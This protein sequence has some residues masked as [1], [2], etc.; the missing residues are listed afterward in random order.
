MQFQSDMLDVP[1]LKANVSEMSALGAAY[2]GGLGIGFWT[3]AEEITASAGEAQYLRYLPS[4]E[5]NRRDELYRGWKKAVSS[6][7]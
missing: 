5:D 1:V 4:M 6:V 7:L 2:M 3:S